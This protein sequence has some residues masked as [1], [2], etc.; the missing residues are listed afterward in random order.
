MAVKEL[1]LT[2]Q[3]SA[4]PQA[5]FD[6]VADLRNYGKWLPNSGVYTGT[7]NITPYPLRVGTTYVE[8]EAVGGPGVVTEFDPPTHIGFRQVDKVPQP[9]AVDVDTRIRYSFERKNGGTFVIR[10]LRMTFELAALLKI[11]TPL[12]VW[13][14]RRENLRTLSCLKR[15]AELA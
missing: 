6:I 15:Y 9:F 1:R 13:A 5:V 14:Y 3:V 10:D 12:L 8:G 4:P 7:H 11:A 2:A